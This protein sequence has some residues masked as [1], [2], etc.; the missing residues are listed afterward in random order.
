MLH[1]LFHQNK[2]TRTAFDFNHF[3]LIPKEIHFKNLLKLME[4]HQKKYLEQ[5]FYTFSIIKEQPVFT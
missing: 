2:E 4:L 1:K 3:P 5:V